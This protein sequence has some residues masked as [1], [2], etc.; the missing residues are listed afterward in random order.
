[1]KVVKPVNGPVHRSFP[2]LL[3]PELPFTFCHC[4]AQRNSTKKDVNSDR[5]I[6]LSKV[7]EDPSLF[8]RAWTSPWFLIWHPQKLDMKAFLKEV[9]PAPVLLWVLRRRSASGI[10]RSLVL[11]KRKHRSVQRMG[12][13]VD[14]GQKAA[15]QTTLPTAASHEN[16]PRGIDQ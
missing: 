3:I 11:G 15:T 8:Y 7:G 1:M 2:N 9:L 10:L 4:S 14:I 13:L 12:T 6:K 16:D 5:G